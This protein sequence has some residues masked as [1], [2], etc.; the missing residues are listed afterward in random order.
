M[1]NNCNLGLSEWA[2]VQIYAFTTL[3]WA[4]IFTLCKGNFGH[5]NGDLSDWM[6]I[7]RTFD[8]YNYAILDPSKWMGPYRRS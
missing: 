2:L 6:N 3:V 4:S 1:T 5:P 8:R 7:S